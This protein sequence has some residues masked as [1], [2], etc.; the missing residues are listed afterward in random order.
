MALTEITKKVV[1]YCEIPEELTEG[2]WISDHHP[3]A[4]VEC[5][6]DEEDETIDKVQIWL[7]ANYPELKDEDSFFIHIDY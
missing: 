6:I 1:S 2:H 5:H 7:L 3:D 4:F